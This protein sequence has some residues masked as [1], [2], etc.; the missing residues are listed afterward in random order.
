VPRRE[1]TL[2]SASNSMRVLERVSVLAIASQAWAMS[3]EFRPWAG[4]NVE[5]ILPPLPSFVSGYAR[6]GSHRSHTP[7]ASKCQIA[8]PPGNGVRGNSFRHLGG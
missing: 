6:E 8:T 4:R 3:A 2:T 7:L 1:F 5:Q